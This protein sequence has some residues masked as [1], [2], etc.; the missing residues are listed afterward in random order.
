MDEQPK[1]NRKNSTHVYA[2]IRVDRY[3]SEKDP[4]ISV[5]EVHPTWEIAKSEVERLNELV[6]KKG[7]DSEY[8]CQCTRWRF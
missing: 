8:F 7:G 6:R 4:I 3:S 5:K 1:I 2:V